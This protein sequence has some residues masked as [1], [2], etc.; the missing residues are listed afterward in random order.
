MEALVLAG[1]LNGATS[2]S[3][4]TKMGLLQK[5][6]AARVEVVGHVMTVLRIGQALKEI[7]VAN[8]KLTTYAP[9]RGNLALAGKK[10]G[11]AISVLTVLVVLMHPLRVVDV[12]AA[13]KLRLTAAPILT[14]IWP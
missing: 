2:T 5:Q 8:T 13:K 14:L 7:P 3:M 11:V 9:T 10:N 12:E 6:H 1:F 4:P